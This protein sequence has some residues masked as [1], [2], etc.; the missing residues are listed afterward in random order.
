MPACPVLS[1]NAEARRWYRMLEEHLGGN[2]YLLVHHVGMFDHK[3]KALLITYADVRK[4]AVA[5]ASIKS[6]RYDD[7]VGLYLV[8][9]G[10]EARP[11]ALKYAHAI[12]VLM[13]A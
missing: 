12:A 7:D 5:E 8:K 10:A 11:Q 9:A 2:Y 3:C 6:L 4:R 13:G 1:K